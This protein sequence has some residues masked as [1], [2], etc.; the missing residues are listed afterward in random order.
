MINRRQF[1]FSA[2]TLAFIGLSRSAFGKVPVTDLGSNLPAYG[3]LIADRNKLLDLPA[4]FSYKVIS[5][6]GEKMDDG[7]FVPNNADGMGCFTLDDDRVALVRNHE[8]KPTDLAK[9]DV[10][11]QTHKTSL[12]Y[13]TNDQGIALPGGTS[14]I[15]YNLK[16][17][18]KEQEYLSLIGT[19]RNCSG[20]ITPWGT[21]LTCEETT[22]TKADG[23]GQDHGYI[24]EISAKAKG[25]VKPEPLKAMGR[26]NHEAAAIDPKTGIVYLTEDKGDSLFYRFIPNEYGRLHKGGQLQAMVIKNAPQFD[27]RNWTGANMTL[28]QNMDVE[29]IDLDNPESPKDDLRLRGYQQGAA[30]FA[31]GEG[32]HWG[33]NELYFCCTNG[34]KKQLGQVMKYVPSQFEGTSKE[35][36]APGQIQLFVESTDGSLYNFGDNLTVAPNGHLIVCEDQYTDV[37]DNHLRGVTPKGE[38]YNFAKLQ[39]Q[40]ELAGAC[41]SPDGNTLFV[42]VFTPTKTLAITGPWDSFKL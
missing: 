37:V 29:W 20:G 14:H 16:T 12:A 5:E 35:Q 13:D 34:G 23:F 18:K 7:Q 4:G 27:T 22:L 11:A 32:I 8:L 33:D 1:L 28:H 42:N 38:V 39:A 3:P 41:F 2:G 24:F 30:L 36:T 10:A 19:I 31:R 26:F 15:I 21:W 6:L 40:T 25:L 9:A 17:A